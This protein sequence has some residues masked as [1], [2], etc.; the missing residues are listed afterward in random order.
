MRRRFAWVL[1][2]T[3]MIVSVAAAAPGDAQEQPVRVFLFGDQVA[4]PDQ[5]PVI[6]DGRTLVPIRGVFEAMGAQVKWEADARRVTVSWRGNQ[7][8]VFIGSRTAWVN[9]QQ[10]TLDVAPRIIGDRTMV[11]LRFLAES[12]G[13]KVTWYERYRT[14]AIGDRPALP[15]LAPAD[16]PNIV[17]PC[18]IRVAIRPVPKGR[19]DPL[20]D[21]PYEVKE[22]ELSEYV[23]R[24][25]AHE[26]GDFSEN[27]GTKHLFTAEPLK[28][29]AIAV[30]TYAWA[31][32]WNPAK[33]DYDLDNSTNFQVYIPDKPYE[34][35]HA[36]AVR[37]VW[38]TYLV[39]KDSGAVFAPQHG[40]G[41]YN[42]RSKGADWMNQQGAL[43]LADK[44]N[45]NWEQ[46]LRYYYRNIDVRNHARP[47]AGP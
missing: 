28:A 6:V 32:A 13:M 5:Q 21:G 16:N 17:M 41:W 37:A 27:D 33:R 8:A 44:H 19:R 43:F 10:K 31:H 25:L 47:C 29:G 7:A 22:V 12:L 30:L 20:D 2:L 23:V 15:V 4:F 14:V 42:E 3:L 46:I 11:P 24:V 18:T 9:G 26:F 39:R 38:G 1:I 34:Q 45:Y 36:D 40:S 35:K